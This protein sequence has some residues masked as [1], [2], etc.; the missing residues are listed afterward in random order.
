MTHPEQYWLWQ[1]LEPNDILI[2]GRMKR[3]AKKVI[4]ILAPPPKKLTEAE[5]NL[6][7]D[8]YLKRYGI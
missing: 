1:Q 8:E 7:Q 2:V 5:D 6:R 3:E 4:E